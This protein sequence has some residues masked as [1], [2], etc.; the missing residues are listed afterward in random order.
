[1]LMA[2]ATDLLVIFPALEV[3]SIAVY[4]LT[5]IRRDSPVARKRPSVFLLG[6]F[7]RVLLRHVH[8]RRHRQHPPRSDWQRAVAHA[9]RDA[10][11]DRPGL[12][13]VGFAFK[14]SAVPSGRPTPTR[15]RRRS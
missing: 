11:A 1:M 3:L 8:P 14:V 12:L 2:T 6:A 5:G 10:A 7:E 4:V 9:Q 13:I 15:A